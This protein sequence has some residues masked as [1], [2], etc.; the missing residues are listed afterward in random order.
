MAGQLER[1][2]VL[3]VATR[4]DGSGTVLVTVED[5]G[6]GLTDAVRSRLFE[7]FFTTKSQG[8]GMGL[9]FCRS[10]IE[11]HGGRLW[12]DDNPGGGAIFRFT[13]PADDDAQPRV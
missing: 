9:L 10:V 7:P 6:S 4:L 13:L 2:G 12:A 3:R 5:D 11:G 1:P 8:L